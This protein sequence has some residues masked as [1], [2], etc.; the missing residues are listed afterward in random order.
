MSHYSA[1]KVCHYKDYEEKKQT[2]K[3][4]K[5]KKEQMCYRRREKE[6]QIWTTHK[7]FTKM[8][9]VQQT[10]HNLRLDIK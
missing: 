1:Q 7:I 2:T 8:H 10:K 5:T 9:T 3:L 6:T 4:A